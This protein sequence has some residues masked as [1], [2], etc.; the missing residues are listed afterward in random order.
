MLER[1]LSPVCNNQIEPEGKNWRQTPKKFCSERCK[2]ETW[3]LR[4]TADLLSCFSAEKKIEILSAV[5]SRNNQYETNGDNHCE[6]TVENQRDVNVPKTYVCRT[7]PQL[8]IGGKVRFRNGLFETNDPE[9][10]QL[11]EKAYGFGVH[12]LEVTEWIIIWNQMTL[13][14][15]K[16]IKPTRE[17][18]GTTTQKSTE[19]QRRYSHDFTWARQSENNII[20]HDSWE[21]KGQKNWYETEMA[22]GSD[23]LVGFPWKLTW[24]WHRTTVAKISWNIMAKI[25]WNHMPFWEYSGANGLK[26]AERVLQIEVFRAVSEPTPKA[27]KNI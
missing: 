4:K 27:W 25:T 20:Q 19:N 9:I 21:P 11:V 15:S 3:A 6:S 13:G 14:G 1:C 17:I 16:P 18:R 7:W 5:S 22:F 10:Q 8:S 24:N 2:T 23:G 12:I 26:M